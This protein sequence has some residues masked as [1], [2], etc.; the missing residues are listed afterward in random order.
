MNI[1]PVSLEA[2]KNYFNIDRAGWSQTAGKVSSFIFSH[3]RGLLG[4]TLILFPFVLVAK[5]YYNITDVWPHQVLIANILYSLRNYVPENYRVGIERYVGEVY[6]ANKFS[7]EDR[8]ELQEWV[9][10]AQPRQAQARVIGII[11]SQ[12]SRQRLMNCLLRGSKELEYAPSSFLE[13]NVFDK[14]SHLQSIEFNSDEKLDL[15]EKILNLKNLRSLRLENFRIPE[16]FEFERLSK[17]QQLSLIKCDISNDVHLEKLFFLKKL[18]ISESKLEALPFLPLKNLVTLD[19]YSLDLAVIPE[20]IGGLSKLASLTLTKCAAL[21]SLPEEIYRLPKGCKINIWASGLAHAPIFEQ[22]T[23]E[24]YSGPK[25]STE[26]RTSSFPFRKTPFLRFGA[27]WLDVVKELD[28]WI[29]VNK[30]NSL[31]RI[32][33][34]DEIINRSFI[35][36]NFSQGDELEN[37]AYIDMLAFILKKSR[38]TG[39]PFQS[40]FEFCPRSVVE[41]ERTLEILEYIADKYAGSYTM[42]FYNYNHLPLEIDFEKLGGLLYQ[43]ERCSRLSIEG[44]TLRNFGYLDS[45]PIE[46]LSLENCEIL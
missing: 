15:P 27:S 21:K 46:K 35:F 38:D 16:N 26:S 31:S 41:Y 7:E 3:K 44:F 14:L 45:L 19:L 36:E 1:V 32:R 10:Q 29:H 43:R 25:F 9:N 40:Y 33:F 18:R 11:D 12:E 2:T 34:R 24:G 8:E 30:E 4:L 23:K 37:K 5:K 39:K 28:K 22:T 13:L 17:I 42:A 20:W 6:P